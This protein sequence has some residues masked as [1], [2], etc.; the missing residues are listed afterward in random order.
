MTNNADQTTTFL[1]TDIKRYVLVLVTLSTD[2]N[3]ELLEQ[4]KSCFKRTI[5]WN[6]YESK[7]LIEIPNQNLDFLIDPSVYVVNTLFISLFENEAQRTS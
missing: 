4:L 1:I 5:N 2:D 7:K 3:T 6:K